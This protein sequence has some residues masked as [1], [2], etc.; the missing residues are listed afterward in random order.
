M[1][2]IV[3]HTV[4]PS[5]TET[6][7]RYSIWRRFIAWTKGQEENR[8]LWLALGIIGHG[9][10]ITIMTMLAIIYSG[11]NFI[12]W[13]FAITSMVI[14]VV[15]NLAAMPTRITIPVFFFSMLIDLVVII[16]CFINGFDTTGIYL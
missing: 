7:Y 9:C 11:N 3:Q 16:A 4:T 14:T 2:T 6:H 8:L 12:F 1:E 10:I 5:Y 15:S 13:P